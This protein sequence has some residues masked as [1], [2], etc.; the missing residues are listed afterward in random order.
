MSQQKENYYLVLT[1]MA[2]IKGGVAGDDELS[3]GHADLRH[4]GER[5][6]R[7]RCKADYDGVLV[8]VRELLVVIVMIKIQEKCNKGQEVR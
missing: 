7:A 2:E 3:K 6:P 1:M 8:I 4:H 5:H